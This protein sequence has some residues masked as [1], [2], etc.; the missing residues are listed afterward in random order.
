MSV[1]EWVGGGRWSGDGEGKWVVW[2]DQGRVRVRRS[3]DAGGV[4]R[5]GLEHGGVVDGELA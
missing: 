2:E 1:F 3:M 5:R 4:D